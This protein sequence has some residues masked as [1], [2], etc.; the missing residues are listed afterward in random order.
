MLG[1]GEF[2]EEVVK[3][4]DDLLMAEVKVLTI[5]QYLPPSERHARLVEYIKPEIFEKFKNIGLKKGF[6][7]VESGSLVRSSY[8][9]ERHVNV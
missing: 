8:H 6:R 7:Y 4:M 1:L 2:E 5:G 9:A 3:T